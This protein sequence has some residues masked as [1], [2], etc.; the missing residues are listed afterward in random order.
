M[1]LPSP[2]KGS[3]ALLLIAVLA[4][5]VGLL[6]GLPSAF[7]VD[8][9]LELVAGRDIWQA[10]IPHTE[11][12]TVIAHGL[13]W[14]DQQWLSQLASYGL[15]RIGGLGLLGV[16]NVALMVA[17][18][19]AAVWYS[20]SRGARPWIILL[21]LGFCLWQVVPAREV[22]TQAFAMPL[23]VAT[24]ILLCSD[25]RRPS[26]RIYWCLPILV[27]WANLHG[28]VSIGAAL[29]S[30]RGLTLAWDRRNQL[31]ESDSLRGL[32]E[33]LR[34][35]LVLV[36]VA[37]LTLLMTPYGFQSLS[38]YRATM[39]NSALKY[40][41]TEWQPITSVWVQA[42]PFFVLA[43]VTIW[44]FGRRPDR[45]TAWEKITLV[46]L[47]AG[48][49]YAIRNSML[50]AFAALMILP[51][52]LDGVI[53]VRDRGEVPVRHRLNT[54]LCCA[55]VSLLGVATVST[56][57]RPASAFEEHYQRMG[58]LRAVETATSR[59]PALRV[60]TDVRS[61]DWLLWRDPA[62]RAKVASDARFEILP[63][64]ALNKLT[65]VFS[66]QGSDWKQGV[67]GYALLVLD[68]SA[69]PD[70]VKAFLEEPGHKV[71]Y[72]D[73]SRIV[74]LRAASETG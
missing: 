70:T 12:L 36:A 4:V 22:R 67:R 37:P 49:I 38:Y 33:Q 19:G 68:R 30:L 5:A 34:R 48:S 52:A 7:S 40:A 50:F 64:P 59:D 10:G 20:R 74:I 46:S 55:V 39:M 25:S 11:T 14:V 66:A 8:S 23:L 35:P 71:L 17:A 73:G 27:L 31:I 21:I 41:V 60:L 6:N 18:V 1:G 9:W 32:F 56:L 16:V 26:G 61:S 15:Y 13:N 57:F 43:A 47:A 54:A 44:S 53:P 65:R 63:Q 69:E 62:L 72:N 42:V 45:T 2:P 3:S 58:V 29:V 24:L 28:T 51:I